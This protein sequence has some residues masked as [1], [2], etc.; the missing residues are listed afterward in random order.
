MRNIPGRR[1]FE[2][3]VWFL[4]CWTTP[5]TT[6]ENGNE[7]KDCQ[8]IKPFVVYTDNWQVLSTCVEH[9]VP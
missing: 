6:R 1:Y 9:D 4:P 7:Q 5:E 3:V 2:T 8:L